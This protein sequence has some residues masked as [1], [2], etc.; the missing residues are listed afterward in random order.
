[1]SPV[2]IKITADQ[3]DL[4]PRMFFTSA[5][6]GSPAAA[7]ETVVATL[8]ITGDIAASKG[9]FLFGQ[10]AYTVGTSGASARYRLRQTGTS[11][12]VIFDSGATTQGI[13]AAALINDSVQGVDTTPVL[14]GQVYV[15]TLQVGSAAAASTV[16]AVS[17][18]GI[19][20]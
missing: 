15:L 11:G 14:P 7:A 8:N 9:V 16:S 17:L 5:V 13:V 18:I 2:P 4:G 10:M 19:V 3:I 6:T 1:M 20:V 12:A